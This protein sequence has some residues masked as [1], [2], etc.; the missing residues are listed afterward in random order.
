VLLFACI[1]SPPTLLD[2]IATL[3]LQRAQTVVLDPDL[4]ADA[5]TRPASDHDVDRFEDELLQ[6]GYVLSLDLAMMIR[7]LPHEALAEVKR[8]LVATLNTPARPH[9]PPFKLARREDPYSLYVQRVTTWLHTRAEQ[10]CPW[11]TEVTKVG[12]LDPC[13]HLVCARCWRSG[14]FRG[15]PICHRRVPIEDPFMKTPIGELRV[16]K[17]D[18]LLRVLHLA[19]DLAA[20]AKARFERLMAK[21]TALV[22]DER[23]E[24]EALIDALGPR[25]AAWIPS[26]VPLRETLALAVGRLW[27]IAADRMEM[28]NATRRHLQSATD[29]LRVAAVVMHANASLAQPMRLSSIPR[30]MRRALLGALE[31]LPVEYVVEDMRKHR[32]LWKRVGERLHPGEIDTPTVSAGFAAARGKPA[33]PTWA[34]RLE[35]ALAAGDARRA[36]ALLAER[37]AEMLRRADHV[38]RVA[39]EKQP[40]AV[41]EV[42]TLLRE[43]ASRCE[44]K[45]LL[46]LAAHVAKRARLPADVIASI[47]STVREVLVV[48]ATKKRHFARAV[49]DRNLPQWDVAAIHAAARANTIYVRDGASIAVYKQ[50]E[51]EMPIERLARLHRG[52]H[53]GL[54]RIP[55]ANAPTWF[56]LLREDVL[57]ARGS[58]GFAVEPGTYA[59]LSAADLIAS[60]A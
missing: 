1:R 48:R 53:D 31:Q 16:T 5:A 35:A 10:P 47:S 24:L 18:G 43:T 2:P 41:G 40:A 12:A 7:R 15:C 20:V 34:G 17:H 55:P 33:G 38:M 46:A 3:L 57:L 19:F 26:D 44:P 56:A 54:S 42:V 25:V 8:W 14:S 29:V 27:I 51:A 9:A 21:P 4:A 30:N 52:E 49:I 50:R 13:G 60:L 58:E 36:A 39:I 32:N 22:A 6:L 28:M 59:R 11:C 23:A 37:P 45:A